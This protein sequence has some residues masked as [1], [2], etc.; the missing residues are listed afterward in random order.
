MH[1][2]VATYS[3]L[4]AAV[5]FE[6]LGVSFMEKSDGM[7]HVVFV[8]LSLGAY[9]ASFVLGTFILKV[10]P[11][12]VMYAVWCGVGIIL[13]GVIG[14]FINKQNLDAPVLL[15]M[16]LIAAGVIVTYLYSKDVAA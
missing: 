6:A 2:P 11:M 4:F 3:L 1:I 5:V 10:M 15:G 13:V 9:A 7:T 12:G 8:V 16:A 14:F